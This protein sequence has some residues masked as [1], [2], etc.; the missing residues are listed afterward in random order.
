MKSISKLIP[1][2]IKE[3]IKDLINYIY[4]QNI[5]CI[6]CDNPIKLTNSYSLCKSCFK[7]LNF[8]LD[9]CHKCGKPI[10]NRN[11]ERES[12]IECNYCYNKTFYFDKAISCIE[13][14]DIS[15][16]LILDFKYKSKT[17]LCKY[18]AYLMK[19]KIFLYDIK[20]D[21]ILFVPLH[22]KRLNKRGFNQSEKI[23]NKLG[24]LLDIPVLDCISRVKN[25][26]KLYKLNK[27]DRERE[28]KNGF[29][30]KENIN[31]IRNKDV[32]LVDDIFTTGSTANEISKV[33]KI[34]SVN[35]ICIFTLLT[36]YV[37]VY[38]K[39]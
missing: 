11:L 24:E 15:K 23:A 19:E 25:T 8:I 3:I 27:E 29:K 38:V 16:K 9:E 1:N 14:D 6:I 35:S 21:Y 34:N 32:I 17:Y 39:K 31:I 30:V 12:L 20:C 4:P 36:T 18:I 10:V 22:K 33:L 37:D 5:S 26:K 7:E 2:N 28:L 13:Y